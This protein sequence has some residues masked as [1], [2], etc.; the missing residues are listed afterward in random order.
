MEKNKQMKTSPPSQPAVRRHRLCSVRSRRHPA[1]T[2]AETATTPNL[3]TVLASQWFSFSSPSRSKLHHRCPS[4]LFTEKI[5]RN[6]WCCQR[7]E[8]PHARFDLFSILPLDNSVQGSISSQFFACYC[9]YCE[10]IGVY[11]YGLFLGCSAFS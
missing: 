5:I 8:R 9:L 6:L 3:A 10:W 4:R 2:I 11:V 1:S 7:G